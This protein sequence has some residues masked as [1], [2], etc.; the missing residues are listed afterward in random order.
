MLLFVTGEGG[1]GK[2]RI[3]DAIASLCRSWSRPD[4]IAKVALTGSAACNIDGI[5]L[6]RFIGH[7][8]LR[9]DTH[10]FTKQEGSAELFLVRIDE[11]SMMT[12][13]NLYRLNTYLQK[14][15]SNPDLQYGGVSVWLSADFFQLPPVGGRPLYENLE[16]ASSNS[17]N[18]DD[19][20][21]TQRIRYIKEEAIQG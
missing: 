2:S 6:D 11:C 8:Y 5:T 13:T 10:T 12:P 17:I 3:I 19:D 4:S 14:L 7:Q 15:K 16:T 1:T 20:D 18:V 9:S 21:D